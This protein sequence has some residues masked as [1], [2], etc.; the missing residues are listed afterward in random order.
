MEEGSTLEPSGEADTAGHDQEE[1]TETWESETGEE[2]SSDDD[3]A[4]SSDD[5]A[6]KIRSGEW[7]TRESKILR[8]AQR[9]LAGLAVA[10]ILAGMVYSL[11][12][13]THS[14]KIWDFTSEFVKTIAL[15]V[16]GAYFSSNTNT[17]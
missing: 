8:F 16:I 12:V 5:G 15:L 1:N 17:K 14:E 6:H 9:I 13:T 3:S 7:T 11:N 4:D 2:E 10:L